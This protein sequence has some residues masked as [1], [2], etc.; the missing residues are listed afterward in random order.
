MKECSTLLSFSEW[1]PHKQMQFIVIPRELIFSGSFT[2]MLCTQST[3]S[4]LY[5][6]GGKKQEER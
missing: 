5:W 1:E 2:L 3:Y 4:N 6:E